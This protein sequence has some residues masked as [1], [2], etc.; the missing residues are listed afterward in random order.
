METRAFTKKQGQYLAFVYAYTKV[1]GRPPAVTDLERH[2]EV[3]GATAQSMVNRLATL[4][5]IHREP[6]TP[7]S[8]RILIPPEDLPVLQ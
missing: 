8:I 6:G 2:F 7:R 3:T 1:N 4:G 5:L